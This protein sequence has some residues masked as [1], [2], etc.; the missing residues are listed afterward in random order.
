LGASILLLPFPALYW[1]L[2][3]THQR[4][5]KNRIS[6]LLFDVRKNEPFQQQG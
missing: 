1:Y 6:M 2:A 3:M 5:I 4:G